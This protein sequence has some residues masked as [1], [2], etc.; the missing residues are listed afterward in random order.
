M[1]TH[2]IRGRKKP[3][4]F[5]TFLFDALLTVLTG[6]LWLIWVVFRALRTF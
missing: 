6:G 2:Y 1:G 4:T 3:Y 5:G